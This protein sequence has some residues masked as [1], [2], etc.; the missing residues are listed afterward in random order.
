MHGGYALKQ[1]LKSWSGLGLRPFLLPAFTQNDV[2]SSMMMCVHTVIWEDAPGNQ[3]CVSAFS[4]SLPTTYQSGTSQVWFHIL[5]ILGFASP[6]S[7]PK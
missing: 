3:G 5:L 1:V 7:P 4:T 2:Y 6:L